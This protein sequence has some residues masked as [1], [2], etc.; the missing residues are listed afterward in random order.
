MGGE[1]PLDE[2]RAREALTRLA[3]EMSEA[4]QRRVGLREAAQGVLRVVRV[5][6]ERALR[7][8]SIE[9]GFDPRE[10][11]LVPFGGAGGLHA[12]ELARALRIPSVVAPEMAGALSATGALAADVV[13]DWSRTA[14]LE[15]NSESDERIER[16]FGEMERE[17]RRAL[18]HEGFKEKDQ[19]HERLLAVRYKGQSFELEIKWRPRMSVAESF[20]SAHHLRYGYAQSEN[21]VEIVS[22]RLRSA[23][24][25]EKLKTH[26]AARWKGKGRAYRPSD[27]AT[28]YFS[29]RKGE[30]T[31]VY[32]RDEL[33]A[34]ARLVSPCIVTEYSATTLVPVGAR[35]R[36]DA[37]GNIII[38][39]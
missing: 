5:Q 36:V 25:V 28:V 20:H 26:R 15:A 13:K 21:A 38:E 17:A 14:M 33:K 32:K 12:V 22:A 24:L 10:F 27:Y 4:A 19:H 6:M 34:G 9:R 2:V 8:I 35:A 39:P 3:E 18:A 16:A 31:A 30:R 11:A 1:F 23:G 37:Y 29:G 7:T